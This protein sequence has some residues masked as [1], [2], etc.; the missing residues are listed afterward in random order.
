MVLG[1]IMNILVISQF[2]YPESFS[3]TPL[4]EGLVKAGHQITVVTSQPQYGFEHPH[5]E[6]RPAFEVIH[7]VH[8]HR[9]NVAIRKQ[10]RF[11][12]LLNYYSYYDLSKRFVSR[13]PAT[14]D[15]VFSMSF[16]PVMSVSAGIDYA[17]K[18]H[19][20]HLLYA[21]DLWPEA[22]IVS[23]HLKRD[24]WIEK[25]VRNISKTIYHAVNFILVGSPGHLDYFKT[26][27]HISSSKMASLIQPTLIEHKDFHRADIASHYWVY[28]GNLGRL[29]PIGGLIQQLTHPSM[30]AIR[31][32]IL[33]QGSEKNKLEKRV[34]QLG[35]EKRVHFLGSLTP[36][37]ST[38]YLEKASAFV[39]AL[40]APGFIGATIPSKVVHY[41]S[42][43]KPIMGLLGVEGKTWLDAI[44]GQGFLIQHEEDWFNAMHHIMSLNEAAYAMTQKKIQAYYL[45][46]LSLSSTVSQLESY[47]M[48]L[49]K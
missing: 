42:Y 35:L 41:L 23:G 28:A 34:L 31:L 39:I 45:K 40:Q 5:K 7:G 11:S 47:L 2:Y 6:I 20:K 26:I 33:G 22:A 14:F 46:H 3:I 37:Q 12:I 49:S 30:R 13:L 17:K 16:S 36:E 10:S 29:Q 48:R 25:W 8:I 4:C 15:V 44:Q 24:S 27:H 18:H 21:V 32:D 38:P 43:G 9:L 1:S 19:K